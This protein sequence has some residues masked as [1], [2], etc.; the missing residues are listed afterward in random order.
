VWDDN[1]VEL[2]NAYI[3]S[4]GVGIFFFSQLASV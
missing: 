3:A 2:G 1:I 4:L